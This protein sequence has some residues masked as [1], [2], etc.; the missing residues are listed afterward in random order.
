MALISGADK[1]LFGRITS[2]VIER[3]LGSITF[4]HQAMQK[5]QAP[6]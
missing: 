6:H 1:G 3:G 2:E 5:Y 4:L